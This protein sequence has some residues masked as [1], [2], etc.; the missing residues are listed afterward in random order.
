MKGMKDM[1]GM[2][3]FL[4]ELTTMTT[5]VRGA[6][7]AAMFVLV[8]SPAFA[9]MNM[10]G[11]WFVSPLIGANTGGDTTSSSP[12]VGVSGGWLSDSW[13]G[14]EAELTWT[15]GFFEQDGFL[16]NRRMRTFTGNALVQLPGA[17]K[18]RPYVVGGVGVLSPHLTEAGRFSDVDKQQMGF[19]V[20]GGVM[21]W[22]N[23]VGVRG[24]VRYFRGMGDDEPNAFGIAFS[25]INFWRI[26]TGMTVRF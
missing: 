15:P 8:A 24:D 20:G 13:L 25:E 3:S 16:I 5:K 1:K 6:V 10:S 7:L 12:A 17:S 11:R 4:K 2:K 19:D 14:V 21:F 23:N 26:S 9:Q 18:A 22:H